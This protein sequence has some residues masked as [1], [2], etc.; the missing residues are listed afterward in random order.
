M[1][2]H[3]KGAKKMLY[4]FQDSHVK[5]SYVARRGRAGGDFTSQ[6]KLRFKRAGANLKVDGP[7]DGLLDASLRAYLE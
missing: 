3:K 5:A 1:E 6:T 7:E 4:G 2:V